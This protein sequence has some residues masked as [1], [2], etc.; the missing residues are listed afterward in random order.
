MDLFDLGAIA[1]LCGALA[2]AW[3]ISR[4]AARRGIDVLGIEALVLG[5]AAGPY[6]QGVLTESVLA[7]LGPAASFALGAL[8]FGVGL[9]LRIDDFRARPGESLRITV[10][11]SLITLLLV[12]GVMVALLDLLGTGADLA[13]AAAVL[14]AAA[15]L[16]APG[17]VEKVAKDHGAAGKVTE[18]IAAVA[19]YSQVLGVIAFGLILCGLHVGE[20]SVAG[21]RPLVPIE[22]AVL[23]V[24]VGAAVG[25]LFAWF[26]GHDDDADEA[27][28]VTLLGMLLFASG[29]AYSLNLSPLMVCL[30]VGAVVANISSAHESLR[31]AIA[32]IERPLLAVV[33]F[34][35][36]GAWRVPP[37]AAW[38]L[39][40]AYI[41]ARLLARW[42]GGRAAATLCGADERPIAR[43]GLSLIGQGGLT[44]AIALNAWQVYDNSL[45]STV[46]TCLLVAAVVN[47]LP[48]LRVVRNT[49]IDAGELKAD[50]TRTA[51][52]EAS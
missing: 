40:A 41:G 18:L 7:D 24:V 52:L 16:A 6:G 13:S 44:V 22:W 31:T 43:V 42:V 20:T 34:F 2:A 36:A 14:T 4:I 46:L 9:R 49:L 37:H 23:A 47:S 30:V 26:L 3:L 1:A 51:P 38:A 35:A 45:T 25:L 21:G 33:V 17:A 32:T 28:A 11:V 50:P 29:V 15:L 27:L 19:G 48:S 5:V 10:V 39:V 8:G 12:G